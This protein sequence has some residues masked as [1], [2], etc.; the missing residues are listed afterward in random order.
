MET[1]ARNFA[2][3]VTPCSQPLKLQDI[4]LGLIFQLWHHF[5]GPDTCIFILIIIYEFVLSQMLETPL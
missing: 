3:N 5:H 4:F 1:I 2:S